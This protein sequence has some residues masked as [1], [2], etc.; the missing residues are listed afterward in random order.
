MAEKELAAKVEELEIDRREKELEAT[1]KRP[2]EAMHFQAKLE[3]ESD[4]Y[5][6]ELDAKGKAAGIR[7][8]G[9]S[10]AEAATARGKAEADGDAGQ[11]RRRGRSTPTRRSPRW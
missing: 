9:A 5:K 2:A 8:L 3:A 4:A 7:L 6:K 11:G 10:E 1:V